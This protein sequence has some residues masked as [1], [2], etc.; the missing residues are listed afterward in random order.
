MKQLI[1]NISIHFQGTAKGKRKIDFQSERLSQREGHVLLTPEEF[2]NY[3]RN[4]WKL[5]D[6]CGYK[7]ISKVRLLVNHGENDG[8]MTMIQL[9]PKQTQ[10]IMRG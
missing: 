4:A 8:E 7:N 1:T 3:E 10:L 6:D 2:N 5:L 9:L